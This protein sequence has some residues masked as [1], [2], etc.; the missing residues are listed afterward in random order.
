MPT[1][2]IPEP[3]KPAVLGLF[4][5][6]IERPE[7]PFGLLPTEVYAE[8]SQIVIEGSGE[9]VT[10]DLDEI[11]DAMT[12]ITVLRCRG[13]RLPRLVGLVLRRRSGAVRPPRPPT[14]TTRR[15]AARGGRA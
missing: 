12:G 2:P 14:P 4:T 9:N 11:A 5:R 6:T 13:G 15:A 7:L 8:G 10:I 1:S 3:L